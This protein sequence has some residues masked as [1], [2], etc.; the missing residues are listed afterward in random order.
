[1]PKQIE[2]P[3]QIGTNLSNRLPTQSRS[4]WIWLLSFFV[5]TLVLTMLKEQWLTGDEPN[6]AF[7]A[8]V[9]SLSI[10]GGVLSMF[11]AARA[12]RQSLT[13][14]AMLAISI[15]AN[16]VMQILEIALKLV[17]HLLWQYPGLLYI[18]LVLPLGFLLLVCGW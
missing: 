8:I 13:F 7:Y 14:L 17:Y 1:M 6:V 2:A 3:D 16:T 15:G 18:V 10:L 5:I 12:G 9:P 11:A 4:F